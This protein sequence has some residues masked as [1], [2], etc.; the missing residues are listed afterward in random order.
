MGV[1]A[2]CPTAVMHVKTENASESIFDALPCVENSH[3]PITVRH[4]FDGG[5]MEHEKRVDARRVHT[6]VCPMT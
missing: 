5:G 4:S 3:E 1:V 6:N 2:C